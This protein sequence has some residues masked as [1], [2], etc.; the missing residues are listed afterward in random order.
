MTGSGRYGITQKQLTKPPGLSINF[1]DFESRRCC[2]W[3]G[4]IGHFIERLTRTFSNRVYRE[5]SPGFVEGPSSDE[6][7]DVL[8]VAV[9][10]SNGYRPV[11]E[12]LPPLSED[13]QARVAGLIVRLASKSQYAKVCFS[14]EF[15]CRG[16]CIADMTKSALKLY[17]LIEACP[18]LPHDQG[19]IKRG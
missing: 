10:Q 6:E 2:R 17:S 13:T 9:P 8:M 11:A 12:S 5:Q 3:T 14:S 18:S 4:T 16:T 7:D 1:Q 15:N 19:V